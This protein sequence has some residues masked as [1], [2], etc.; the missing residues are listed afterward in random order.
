MPGEHRARRLATAGAIWTLIL[1]F[2]PGLLLRDAAPKPVGVEN[3]PHI[4]DLPPVRWKSHQDARLAH[5][6]AVLAGRGVVVYCW[7]NADWLRRQRSW[8]RPPLDPLG[9]WQ[10][11][12]SYEPVV[13]VNLGPNLC[14]ELDELAKRREP[15]WRARYPDALA[16]SVQSLAH[17][18][19]HVAG[20]LDEAT[21]EC[22][23]LQTTALAAVEL[24]RT[25]EE[26][27]FLAERYWR[28]TYPLHSAPY[29]SSE[30][31]DG[32]RLD[33]RPKSHNWP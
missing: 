12:V 28:R 14:S 3:A 25:L 32:G 2:A 26:G 22:W 16:W 33:F 5:V 13:T 20:H 7:S 9:P 6:V 8:R 24:G 4:P 30:C 11:Y 29:W 17:E 19:V 10:A 18:A 15:V 31:R 27:R 21:A 1:L 23:G